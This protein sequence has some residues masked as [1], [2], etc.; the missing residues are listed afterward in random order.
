MQNIYSCTVAM[1]WLKIKNRYPAWVAM[2]KK[3][4]VGCNVQK[5]HCGDV[6]YKKN[7]CGGVMYKKS[8][9]GIDVQKVKFLKLFNT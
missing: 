3:I 2:Y 9:L 7:H 6:M 8:L 5:N 4:T 1:L